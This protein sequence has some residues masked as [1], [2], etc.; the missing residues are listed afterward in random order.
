M[1]RLQLCRGFA[2]KRNIN[3]KNNFKK[4]QGNNGKKLKRS[5]KVVKKVQKVPERPEEYEPGDDVLVYYVW[6]GERP[7]GV[8]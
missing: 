4:D 3:H 8:G 2:R 6:A 7:M 1:G 5:R